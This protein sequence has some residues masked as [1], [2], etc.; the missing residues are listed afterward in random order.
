VGPSE[1]CTD[2]VRAIDALA[3]RC[4]RRVAPVG[5]AAR[6]ALAG[7]C[8]AACGRGPSADGGAVVGGALGIGLYAGTPGAAVGFILATANVVCPGGAGIWPR[9][10]ERMFEGAMPGWA[11]V[12]GGRALSARSLTTPMWPPL[13]VR[14]LRGELMVSLVPTGVVGKSRLLCSHQLSSDET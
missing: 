4:G 8:R 11:A 5:T 14:V 1:T 7:L 2:G 12:I 9:R 13:P 6:V 10:W 3:G